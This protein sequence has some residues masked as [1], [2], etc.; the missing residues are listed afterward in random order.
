VDAV[1]RLG[2]ETCAGDRRDLIGGLGA[3]ERLD[4]D[5]A[6]A[7]AALEL[8]EQ[9]PQRMAA[10]QIV[11]PVGQDEQDG[12]LAQPADQEL[13]HVLRRAVR[14]VD[15]LHHQDERRLAPELL[16][17]PQD[18]AERAGLL[19]AAA[20]RPRLGD[21]RRELA[22]QRLGQQLERLGGHCAQ[23]VGQ[24]AVGQ[25]RIAEIDAGAGQQPGTG[26]QR[27]RREL[28]DEARL[29]DAGLAGDEHGHRLAAAR[30]LERGVERGDVLAAP[31]ERRRRDQPGDHFAEYPPVRRGVPGLGHDQLWIRRRRARMRPPWRPAAVPATRVP[32][33]SRM[34]VKVPVP[35]STAIGAA[36]STAGP[37]YAPVSIGSAG[38]AV[39][40][41]AGTSSAAAVRTV[42]AA[43]RA[44]ISA[45][46]RLVGDVRSLR[47]RGPLAHRACS[48]SLGEALVARMSRSRPGTFDSRPNTGALRAT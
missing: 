16:E 22:P 3:R 24:R 19:A 18:S 15:V 10:V 30:V 38:M 7:W 43:V 11:G 46:S 21:Q 1:D 6:H 13:E 9:R 42:R 25:R 40:E 14:P 39:A 23:R 41:P 12:C 20:G 17:Q 35:E 27:A 5:R 31:D 34:T 2:R 37:T 33:A 48:R 32:P 4:L 29:P 26:R 28:L 45:S 8:G 36:G 44:D 47:L